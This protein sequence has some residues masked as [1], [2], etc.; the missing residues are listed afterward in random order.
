M[1]S[2]VFSLL[3]SVRAWARSRVALQLEMVA[4]RHQLQILERS[5]RR[6]LRLSRADRMLWVWVSRVWTEWRAALV[7]VKP[8]TV[9]A[10]HR[11][12]FRLF[13][14]WKSRRR[15]GRPTVPPDV[16]ALIRTMSEANPLWG[17]PRLHGE[18]LKLG[19]DIGETSVSKYMA[20]HRKPPSQTW[21]TFLENHCKDLVSVDFFTVP[22]IRFQVLYVFLVLAHDRRRIVHFNVTAHPTAEWT[23][24]QLRD[25]FPWNTVPR[26]LLRDRDRI[27]GTM[28]RMDLEAMGIKEVL[29]APHSPWQRAYIERV[30]G[31]VRRECLDH[32]IVFNEASL[33]RTIKSYLVDYHEWRTHLSLNKD[34]PVPRAAQPQACGT[35]VRVA[36]IGGLH[37]HYERRAA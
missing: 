2:V 11:Q 28:F 6:R 16:R 19:I 26:Y 5:R 35:I 7:I 22:T 27:F 17:A 18:L 1:M 3:L 32:I 37:H 29:S 12:G 30:I 25:A 24:Q 13:W 31:S 36:H 20:R 33:R 4:L 9:I 8:Q 15:T 34:A 10:W 21:R 23:A 14:T